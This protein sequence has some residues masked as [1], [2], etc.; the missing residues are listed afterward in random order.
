MAGGVEGAPGQI[1]QDGLPGER[2][3]W[4][5]EHL[6]NGVRGEPESQPGHGGAAGTGAQGN[7]GAAADKPVKDEPQ[8]GQSTT[9]ATVNTTPKGGAVERT[10]GPRPRDFE[11]GKPATAPGQPTTPQTGGNGPGRGRPGQ[12]GQSQG[13]QGQ[14]G[15]TRSPTAGARRIRRGRAAQTG[16]QARLRSSQARPCRRR[17]ARARAASDTET[18]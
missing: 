18:G 15:G 1:A 13:G 9:G 8:G 7:D 11:T 2:T 4:T 10:T 16:R 6:D 17:P 3:G 5:D 12:G 14:G